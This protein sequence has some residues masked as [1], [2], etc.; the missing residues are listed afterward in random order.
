MSKSVFPLRR[1]ICGQQVNRSADG[2]AAVERRVWPANN[3]DAA[4]VV[5]RQRHDA[6]LVA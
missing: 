3:L 4:R 2:G 6:R 1:R 5:D